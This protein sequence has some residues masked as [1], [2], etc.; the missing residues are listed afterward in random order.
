MPHGIKESS[1][2][3][4]SWYSLNKWHNDDGDFNY[5]AEKTQIGKGTKCGFFKENNSLGVFCFGFGYPLT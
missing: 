3:P 2:V 1:T 4:I 5:Y